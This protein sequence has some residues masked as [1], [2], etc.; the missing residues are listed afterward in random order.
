MYG[1]YK[2]VDD[3]RRE[4]YKSMNEIDTL[5]KDILYF[6]KKIKE[7]PQHKKSCELAIKQSDL[8]LQLLILKELNVKNEV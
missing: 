3:F 1:N 2:T 6:K 7:E 4:K 5:N 8:L